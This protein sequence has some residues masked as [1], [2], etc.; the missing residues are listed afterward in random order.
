M[1]VIGVGGSFSFVS[2]SISA[3]KRGISGFSARGMTG[4]ETPFGYGRAKP[5]LIAPSKN[6]WTSGR[7]GGCKSTSGTSVASPVVSGVIAL[8]ISS[9]DVHQRWKLINPASIKQILLESSVPLLEL[10]D[11]NRLLGE[12]NIFSQGSGDLNLTKALSLM[13]EYVPRASAFPSRLNLTDCPYMWP[14]CSQPLFF[15]ARP[16]ILNVTI[17]NAMS[18]IGSIESVQ[19]ETLN[20]YA[21]LLGIFLTL[22]VLKPR[23]AVSLE[24]CF[25]SLEWFFR[26]SIVNS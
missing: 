22:L 18:V 15:S 24:R 16:I 12:G 4:W 3:E 21:S 8:L 11:E 1:D 5:D 19:F 6:I 20:N 26:Y 7:D 9:V 2:S 13:T 10:S 17:L 23:F 25:V 14:Y